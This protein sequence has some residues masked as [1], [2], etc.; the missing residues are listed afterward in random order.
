[1]PLA[2]AGRGASCAKGGGRSAHYL[3]CSSV[4][5]VPVA[6]VVCCGSGSGIIFIHGDA[7]VYVANIYHARIRARA[8]TPF[9]CHWNTARESDD[10]RAPKS[11]S[12]FYPRF[13]LKKTRFK[14]LARKKCTEIIRGIY[15][16]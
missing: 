1:M 7:P 16:Q 15:H 5:V 6:V 11:S 14:K 4:V 9:Q 3:R 2:A 12:Y 13:R 10:V 8:T